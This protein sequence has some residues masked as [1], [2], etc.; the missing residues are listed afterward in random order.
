MSL[1]G[2][3]HENTTYRK[4]TCKS[5]LQSNSPRKSYQGLLPILVLKG[6]EYQNES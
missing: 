5:A 1:K 6:I 2:K 3:L 4:D